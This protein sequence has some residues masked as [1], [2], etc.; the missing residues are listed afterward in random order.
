VAKKVEVFPPKGSAGGECIFTE[1]AEDEQAPEGGR[2][3]RNQASKLAALLV[4]GGSVR[5]SPFEQAVGRSI[6]DLPLRAGETILDSWHQAARDIAEYFEL[7]RLPVRVLLSHRALEPTIHPRHLQTPIRIDRDEDEFRGPGGALGDV[8][9]EFADDELLLVVSGHQMMADPI[10]ELVSALFGAARDGAILAREDGH[11]VTLFLLSC[12]TLRDIPS[13]GFVDFKEQALPR[14]AA[15]FDIR[16]VPWSRAGL[17]SVRTSKDYL[18]GLRQ[19]H[20]LEQ[21]S[22]PG[23]SLGRTHEP[24]RPIFSIV[25]PEARVASGVDLLDSVVLRGGQVEEGAVVVRS[26]VAEG[27]LVRTGQLVQDRIVRALDS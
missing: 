6:M 18:A 9:A 19:V 5:E 21:A 20:A 8:A 7:S 25:E 14:M 15:S 24:W 22:R 1:E 16:V 26:I 3:S 12:R 23:S 17:H 13:V 2:V 4:L 27:G 10:T 11:P